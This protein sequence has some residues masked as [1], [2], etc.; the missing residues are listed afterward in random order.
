MHNQIGTKWQ[1][2]FAK[3]DPVSVEAVGIGLAPGTV[4]DISDTL[5]SQF[6]QVAS[7][8]PRRADI[9][10]AYGMRE[11]AG[12]LIV[13]QNDG[14]AQLREVRQ[15]EG[16]DSR[17]W[18]DYAVYAAFV[19]STHDIQFLLRVRM[20]T[21]QE[22]CVALLVGN[23]FDAIDYLSHERVGDVSRD[24]THRHR[25]LH[26]QAPPNQTGAVTLLLRNLA[27]TP[28]SFRID[29]GAGAKGAR[30]S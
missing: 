30:N 12:M 4:T 26:H 2:G 19:K 10:D 6:Q 13:D 9:V 8:V 24:A 17:G 25:P 29:D 22:N 14:N 1:A 20:G 16:A 27:N 15:V 5:V 21:G 11:G 7:D 3:L 28:R 18:N 23:F